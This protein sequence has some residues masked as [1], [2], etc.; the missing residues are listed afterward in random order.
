MKSIL[1]T[2]SILFTCTAFANDTIQS[3]VSRATVFLSGAQVFRKSKTITVPKGVNEIVVSDVSP[4]LNPNQLQA[5]ANGKFM[6][7]DV[8]YQTEYVPP[9]TISKA[10]IPDKILKEINILNDT[11]LFISLEKE[12][13]KAKL[14]NL[15]EEKRMITQSQLIQSGGISDTLPEF[16]EIVEFY[17]IKLDEINELIYDW[18]IKQHKVSNRENKHQTRLNELNAYR[19]NS[20]QVSEPAK[21]RYHIVVTT[22]ADV[23]TQGTIEVNYYIQ[24]AGWIPA[25]DLRANN[26]SD[27]MIVTYKAHVFQNSG[28]DWNK[29]KLTLSTYDQ[30]FFASRPSM[31]IWRLD[32]TINKPGINYINNEQFV[33]QNFNSKEEMEAASDNIKNAHP[34]ATVQSNFVPANQLAE[35]SQNFS[36]VEFNVK[37][38]Y[39][40][41]ADGSHKLM[42]VTNE[43]IEADFYHYMLPRANKNAFLQ[44]K[45]G[46]WESLSLLPGKANI[47]F[48]QTIVGSTYIDPTIM[49]DTMELTLGRDQGIVATR[50]KIDE[51]QDKTSMGKRVVKTYT[52]EIEVK[53]TSRSEVEVTLE[54][55]IPITSNE[56]IEIKLKDSS[57]ASHDVATGMLTWELKLKPGEKKTVQFTYSI[58]HDKDKPVS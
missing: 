39:S 54:D 45:I 8:Q 40:I 37:L 55:Q 21:T 28:E 2:L 4:Y 20:G 44:A 1:L 51:E 9:K 25:Y 49:S 16:K 29:V 14:N 18:K 26:T 27:P 17:R 7:L 11:M 52:F 58:E 30:S 33:S 53:N 23:A 50:K 31:G 5:T 35:I 46:D 6:V 47:Y 48:E 42:V 57:K 10:Q 32:Y 3:S 22:Y 12:R 36:N 24:N 19:Q 13:I 38:P 56:E 41:K 34:N 15:Q 43:T